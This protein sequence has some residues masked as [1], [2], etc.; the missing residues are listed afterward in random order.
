MFPR[1]DGVFAPGSPS[2]RAPRQSRSC[3]TSIGTWL[4]PG[5]LTAVTR[6]TGGSATARSRGPVQNPAGRGVRELVA[7]AL[8]ELGAAVV[9]VL[10]EPAPQFGRGGDVL[11]PFVDP[12]H[13]LGHA[14]RP[15]AVDEDPVS[16]ARSGGL[17][18]PF[19]LEAGR[20]GQGFVGHPVIA[21]RCPVEVGAPRGAVSTTL[22]ETGPGRRFGIRVG[23]MAQN[24]ELEKL[25]SKELHDRAVKLAVRHGDIRFLWDLLTRIPAAEATAGRA[26]DSEADIKWVVPMLD[27]YAHAGEGELAEALRGFYLEYLT[28]HS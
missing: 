10:V 13:G 22:A 20:W 2:C 14:A 1:P 6:V 24:E 21:A 16:V 5:S 23:D 3:S 4:C 15:Q 26:G 12:C 11:G 7:I 17:V 19:D 25:S 9:G 8:G 27:D 28:E 18:H